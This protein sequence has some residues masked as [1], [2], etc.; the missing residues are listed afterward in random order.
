MASHV[1]SYFRNCRKYGSAFGSEINAR[2]Q[3]KAENRR[4]RPLQEESHGIKNGRR[5]NTYTTDATGLEGGGD[6]VVC[7]AIR[8]DVTYRLAGSRVGNIFQA[9]TNPFS[10]TPGNLI[11]NLCNQNVHNDVDYKKHH[12]N[13]T[14]EKGVNQGS[15]SDTRVMESKARQREVLNC[16]QIY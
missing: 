12:T 14:R 6:A 10:P 11:I 4:R 8:D 2:R 15:K 7:F 13:V 16:E 3:G 9:A 1:G 5:D